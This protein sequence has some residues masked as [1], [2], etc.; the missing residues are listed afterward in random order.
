MTGF[1]DTAVAYTIKA[2]DADTVAKNKQKYMDSIAY[3]YKK[4]NQPLKRLEWRRKSFA[5]NKDTSTRDF[6]DLADA[7]ISA[8]D[9]D[10]ADSIIAA[11]RAKFP[12]QVYPY[13]FAVQNAKLK[14]TTGEAC[15]CANQ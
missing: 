3:I 8:K 5:L 15:C 13:T 11:Y 2:M 9:T 7:A 12:D 1:E 14:D 10:F 6:Y 4:G